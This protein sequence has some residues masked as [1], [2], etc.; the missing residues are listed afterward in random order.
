MKENRFRCIGHVLRSEETE[1]VRVLNGIYV[2]GK[3][4]RRKPKKRW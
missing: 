4:G 2:D 1:T 3:R